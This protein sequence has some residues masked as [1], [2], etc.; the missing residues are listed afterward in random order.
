MLCCG[1]CG[2]VVRAYVIGS[3]CGTFVC[4]C[5]VA[6]DDRRQHQPE[7]QSVCFHFS[8]IGFC[9][10]G[11]S[12]L[13]GQQP[14]TSVMSDLIPVRRYEY[15]SLF[16]NCRGIWNC[17]MIWLGQQ[18]TNSSITPANQSVVEWSPCA[19]IDPNS[20]CFCGFDLATRSRR[21]GKDC[22]RHFM[23]LMN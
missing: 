4:G 11:C 23:Y 19:S 2:I 7:I 18:A 16:G 12:K 5:V 1:I 21:S 6:I 22:S 3:L 10:W 15:P 8:M 20:T 9:V 13:T 14:F 17:R